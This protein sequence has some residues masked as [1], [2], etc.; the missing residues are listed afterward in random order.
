MKAVW[1]VDVSG[2][3]EELGMVVGCGNLLNV[4]FVGIDE[5]RVW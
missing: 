5:I 4:G 2:R 1:E 3:V